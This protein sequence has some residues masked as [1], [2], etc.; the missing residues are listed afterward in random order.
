MGSLPSIASHVCV[1]IYENLQMKIARIKIYRRVLKLIGILDRTFLKCDKF[2]FDSC[3]RINFSMFWQRFLDQQQLVARRTM[4]WQCGAG[5]AV[6][7][8]PPPSISP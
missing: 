7:F 1:F 5:E 2:L 8:L 3:W 6:F 4:S